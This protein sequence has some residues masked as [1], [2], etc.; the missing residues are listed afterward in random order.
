VERHSAVTQVFFHRRKQFVPH[1]DFCPAHV[2]VDLLG[3]DL[4]NHLFCYPEKLEPD[5][6]VLLADNPVQNHRPYSAGPG[7]GDLQTTQQLVDNNI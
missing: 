5:P 7:Q 4:R 1:G 6:A 2:V 3:S